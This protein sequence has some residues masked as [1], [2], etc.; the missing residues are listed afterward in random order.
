LKITL[1]NV[2]SLDFSSLGLVGSMPSY[3]SSNTVS[4]FYTY[5]GPSQP[6][7]KI[8]VA[9]AAGGFILPI[10]AP[11]LEHAPNSSWSLDFF[12]PSLQCDDVSEGQRLAFERN[13]ASYI[14]TAGCHTAA[15]YLAWFPHPTGTN[16]STAEPYQNR[17]DGNRTTWT[18]DTANAIFNTGLND[19]ILSSQ[20]AIMYVAILP[21]MIKAR[22]MTLSA[23]PLA[24][25]SKSF[26]NLGITPTNPLGYVGGNVTMLQC[27]FYNSSYHTEFEYVNGVQSVATSTEVANTVPII[28]VVRGPGRGG[29]SNSS[30]YCATLNE[31]G[32]YRVNDTG[33]GIYG[34]TCEYDPDLLPQ[35]SYQ[36]TLQAFT[37]LITGSITRG[38]TAISNSS[39][40]IVSSGSV[41]LVD[42]SL[43]RSTELLRTREL[44]FLSDI[45]L[46]KQTDLDTGPDL[47]HSLFVSNESQASGMTL[48]EQDAPTKSLKDALETMFQNFTVSLMSSESLRYVTQPL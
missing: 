33:I 41:T 48:N 16:S 6:A 37:D 46:H 22:T 3:A 25:S 14:G 24:C 19:Y 20:Q 21:N 28:N 29:P 23:E 4:L 43:V 26:P 38:S 44:N 11:F 27:Q 47:Q 40:G 9:V 1:Q 8:A 5:N 18:F 31:V 34:E 10:N 36:A 2:P 39:A 32:A 35:L 12:A 30:D 17:S 13:I 42:N 15:P 45:S 7:K